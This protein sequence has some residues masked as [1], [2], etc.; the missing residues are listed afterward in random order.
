[1]ASIFKRT[2][3]LARPKW[4]VKY[5]DANGV[6]HRVAAGFDKSAALA[7]A[8]ELE[9]HFERERAGLVDPHQEEARRPL[10]DHLTEYLDSLVDE[11]RSAVHV[12][13]LRTRIRAILDG[14]KVRTVAELRP[15]RVQAFLGELSGRG[16]SAKTLHHFAASVKG[17]TRFL[18]R[19]GRIGEDPLAT[20]SPSFNAAADRRLVR[21]A[22]D[23]AEQRRLIAAAEASVKPSFGL[24]GRE[25]ALLYRLILSS[26]LRANEAATLTPSSFT[27]GEAPT[28]TVEARYAKNRKRET[29]PLVPDVAEALRAYVGIR[30][31][32]EPIFGG[33]SWPTHGGRMLRVDM[34]AAGISYRDDAGRVI[35]IHG[36]RHTFITNLA[37]A[38]V[39]PQLAQRLARHSDVRLT[40][41]VYSHLG[42][43]D[44]AGALA[45]L[46]DLTREA[47]ASE[48]A[49]GTEGD[50]HPAPNLRPDLRPIPANSGDSVQPRDTRWAPTPRNEERGGRHARG[51]KS[52]KEN[53]G[54][55]ANSPASK[56]EAGGVEP[57][58]QDPSKEATTCVFRD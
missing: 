22:L 21:R 43:V 12:A 47:T 20:F 32:T 6:L 36:L 26:G 49:T 8:H 39:A 9:R 17:F 10:A 11:Q 19:D 13:R 23:A 41:G 28:V 51:R 57:P 25:R 1:M 56:M 3:G 33:G 35:D 46:P 42:L 16:L 5:R 18:V 14:A 50:D 24:S 15:S 27:F 2:A 55:S 38:G 53:A 34:E 54:E 4:Y 29:L 30:P 45:K 37:R 7:K 48:V 44:L 40:L 58:S 52:T 31:A